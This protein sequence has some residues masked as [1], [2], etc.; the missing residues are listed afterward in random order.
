MAIPPQFVDI[1]VLQGVHCIILCHCHNPNMF[2]F[3][4]KYSI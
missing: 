4:C 2:D 3:R 1:Q